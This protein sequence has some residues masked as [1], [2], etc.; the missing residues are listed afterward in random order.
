MPCLMPTGSAAN[1]SPRQLSESSEFARLVSAGELERDGFEPS[2]PRSRDR[3]S[4]ANQILRK[5]IS[6]EGGQAKYRCRL[7]AGARTGP[8]ISDPSS[9]APFI[10]RSVAVAGGVPWS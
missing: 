3:T 9:S 4:E 2:V 1:W 6:A 8:A 7:F 10:S 5:K